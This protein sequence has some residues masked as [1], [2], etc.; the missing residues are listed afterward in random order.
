MCLP[1]VCWHPLLLLSLLLLMRLMAS[2]LLLLLLLPLLLPALL[3]L[4]QRSSC[5]TG[6]SAPGSSQRLSAASWRAPLQL[7]SLAGAGG[8]DVAL[9][10]A[11]DLFPLPLVLLLHLHF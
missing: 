10:S 8:P 7:Q 2:L 3:P 11:V 5:P 1:V 9:A 4:L 6:P